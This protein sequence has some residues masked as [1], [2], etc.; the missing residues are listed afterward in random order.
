MP[1][2][3]EYKMN[4]CDHDSLIKGYQS[5]HQTHLLTQDYYRVLI[6]IDI[7]WALWWGG[8]GC[9]RGGMRKISRGV[10]RLRYCYRRLLS[11]P[12]WAEIIDEKIHRSMDPADEYSLRG[13]ERTGSQFLKEW[14]DRSIERDCLLYYYDLWIHLPNPSHKQK[15]NTVIQSKTKTKKQL[16]QWYKVEEEDVERRSR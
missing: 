2:F 16:K 13:G 12:N 8:Y 10:A 15:K 6:W 1:V 11:H 7:R 5:V 4:K 9:W 14:N 3:I